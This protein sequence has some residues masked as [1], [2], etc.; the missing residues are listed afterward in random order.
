MPSNLLGFTISLLSFLASII[1][2]GMY[3]VQPFQAGWA[4][5]IVIILFVC[6]NYQKEDV[7]DTT[8]KDV[9]S[10]DSSSDSDNSENRESENSESVIS[11]NSDN[12]TSSQESKNK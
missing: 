2:I 6:I 4:S 1:I 5:I 3:F 11:D 9:S 12:E 10:E 7:I 8:K